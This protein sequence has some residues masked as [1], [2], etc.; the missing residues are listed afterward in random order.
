MIGVTPA[1]RLDKTLWPSRG[2][3]ETA[4]GRVPSPD[5]RL[6]NAGQ[7]EYAPGGGFAAAVHAGTRTPT[8]FDVQV[9]DF[10]V[11]EEVRRALVDRGFEIAPNA[12]SG[13]NPA[14]GETV[15]ANGTLRVHSGGGA[16][17]II[18]DAAISE[19]ARLHVGTS[20]PSQGVPRPYYAQFPLCAVRAPADSGRDCDQGVVSTV[21]DF[22][23]S[24]G[25]IRPFSRPVSVAIAPVLQIQ[26]PR[27]GDHIQRTSTLSVHWTTAGVVKLEISFTDVDEG[28]AFPSREH[29][30]G[31]ENVPTGRRHVMDAS[32]GYLLST[33][34]VQ[35]GHLL[36]M[37][38]K[39]MSAAGTVIGETSAQFRLVQ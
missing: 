12:T 6:S 29:P 36:L 11:N 33:D 27:F 30:T 1:I 2:A 19:D 28:T 3:F 21:Y 22:V 25:A 9:P 15:T 5:E 34:N 32:F 24:V 31:T 14:T 18:N 4:T 10:S 16:V 17:S 23:D 39:A 7:I 20:P 38:I 13:T 26:T 8:V 37:R 35:A